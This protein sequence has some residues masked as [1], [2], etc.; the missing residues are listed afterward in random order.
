MNPTPSTT[1]RALMLASLLLAVASAPAFAKTDVEIWTDRG[2]DA[3]YQPGDQMHL[4]VRT[5][6][7]SY[8]LVYEL[9]TQGN[10]NLIYPVKRGTG[11][12]EGKVTF[13]LPEDITQDEL[14]VE[15]ET[16][17]GFIVAIAS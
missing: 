8:L 1:A 2:D 4:K 15:K 13:R 3:V 11:R 9:D 7:D 17:Q 6:Q 10:V 12:I 16:G 5:T 14:V